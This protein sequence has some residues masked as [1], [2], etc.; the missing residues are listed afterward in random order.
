MIKAQIPPEIKDEVIRAL[1]HGASR[2]DL[3]LS[4]CERSSLTWPEAEA[5]VN[6]IEIEHGIEIDT[7]ATPIL[8]ALG[9]LIILGGLALLTAVMTG[10]ILG[11]QNIFAG[12]EEENLIPIAGYWMEG[13]QIIQISLLLLPMALGMIIG[14]GMGLYRKIVPK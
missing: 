10:L 14:G 2:D 5:Y 7:R 3:I 11:L 12:F 13:S 9:G 8:T 6:N 1:S 4:I